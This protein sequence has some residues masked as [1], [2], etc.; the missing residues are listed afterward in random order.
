[1]KQ[2]TSNAIIAIVL[3]LLLCA[4]LWV[5]VAPKGE[6]DEG[7]A[8]PSQSEAAPQPSVQASAKDAKAA[9]AGP[10]KLEVTCPSKIGDRYGQIVP[11]QDF[12]VLGNFEGDS[13]KVAK[14]E[15]TLKDSA[16]KTVQTIHSVPGDTLYS[17]YSRL[18]FYDKDR[19]TIAH[20]LM[21]DLC[22]DPKNPQSFN[23]PWRKC[24]FDKYSFTGLFVGGT[25]KYEN[26][27]KSED[28]QPIPPLKEG[29]YSVS[30]NALDKDGKQ[31]SETSF[32]LR[33]AYT[34]NHVSSRFSPE[35]HFNN[36]K[37]FAK[38]NHYAIFIDPFP[39]NWGVSKYLKSPAVRKFYAEI[40]PRW[41][42]ADMQEYWQGVTHFPIYNVSPT[43]A[44]YN[45]E[46]GT[47]TEHKLI[48]EPKSVKFYYYDIGE[49]KIAGVDRIGKFV[50]FKDGDH[51]QFTRAE[52]TARPQ[53]D[54]K[55]NPAEDAK[56]K[57][58]FDF[59]DGV[60]VPRGESLELFGVVTPIAVQPGDIVLNDD[61]SYTIKDR[62]AT[63]E[64][65]FTSGQLVKHFTKKVDLTRHLGKRDLESI[66]EFKHTFAASP[67]LEG[68][69]WTVSCVALDT[70]GAKV[71]G[72]EESF[73]VD[74][75]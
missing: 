37:A 61:F 71:A 27:L 38:E 73:R 41:R 47:L 72:T 66:L 10:L 17:D 18:S 25:Y 53:P 50:P 5:L 6:D 29:L 57:L 56:P 26:S 13:S 40:K 24:T 59:T 23:D 54:D 49:P 1:M 69:V 19:S 48:G 52:L 35:E 2:K 7:S 55:W 31:L 21:P 36:V 75:Q 3:A 12:Y 11:D 15:M 74:F 46:T 34:D 60:T 67:E 22:Y 68:H 58:D 4:G 64:Y 44:T 62:I 20:C 39:G 9:E 33:V 8:E 43:S 63:V 28:G 32:P 51:L 42:C 65:T 14:I 30:V 16:G 45:V 70:H